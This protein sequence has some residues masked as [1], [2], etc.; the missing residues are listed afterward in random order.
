MVSE[1]FAFKARH[2]AAA[3]GW[4]SLPILVIPHPVGQLPIEQVR[5]IADAAYDEIVRALTRPRDEVAG[6]YRGRVPQG[7]MPVPPQ[8]GSPA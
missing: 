4:A 2:E 5:A 7:K 1:A 8:A 6:F 3:K